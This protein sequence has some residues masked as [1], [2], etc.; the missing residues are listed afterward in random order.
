MRRCGHCGL[1]IGHR[2]T[3]C[4]VCGANVGVEDAALAV[5]L[6]TTSPASLELGDHE[7]LSLDGLSAGAQAVE[8]SQQQLR[9]R[10]DEGSN[11]GSA[12]LRAREAGRCEKAD[13]TRAAALYRQAIVEFLES[14][15]DPLDSPY[16]CGQVLFAFDRLSL[17]LKR[18]DLKA[19][20]LEEIDSAASLGLLDRQDTGTKTRREAL[21]KRGISLRRTL[22][23]DHA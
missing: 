14:S 17:V 7:G 16:V 1:S 8:G 21:S 15:E 6:E 22:A 23:T 4:P 20:A 11:H 10:Q 5:D 12:V 19:E 3:Y 18:S 9:A 2:A 13:A